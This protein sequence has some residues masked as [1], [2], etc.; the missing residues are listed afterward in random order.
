[1]S[2]DT[3]MVTETQVTEAVESTWIAHPE[4]DSLG[5]VELEHDGE[6]YFEIVWSQDRNKLLFGGCCNV[7]FM[8][9]G[10][11]QR[12][13]DETDDELLSELYEDLLAF[14]NDQSHN[15]IVVNDR[16]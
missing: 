9:S 4:G 7:G 12:E 11:I 2:N 3:N 8:Q 13:D 10:Y 14:Y 6:H 5:V 16:M 1:M 15:R